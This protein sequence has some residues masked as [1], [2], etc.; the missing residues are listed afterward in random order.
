MTLRVKK[1]HPRRTGSDGGGSSLPATVTEST[2]PR[3]GGLDLHCVSENGIFIENE[4]DVCYDQVHR[5]MAKVTFGLSYTAY[6]LTREMSLLQLSP[7]IYRWL[8]L[9]DDVTMLLTEMQVPSRL[10]PY[11]ARFIDRLLMTVHERGVRHMNMHKDMLSVPREEEERLTSP[12]DEAN[13]MGRH[14][15]PPFCLD[16]SHSNSIYIAHFDDCAYRTKDV[17]LPERHMGWAEMAPRHIHSSL[18]EAWDHLMLLWSLNKDDEGLFV[19]Q[20]KRTIRCRFP[21]LDEQCLDRAYCRTQ[22]EHV[23]S[24]AVM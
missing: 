22:T 24:T 18:G 8:A 1:L 9:H 7:R 10:R 15:P 2:S 13:P 14:S 23:C 3:A 21:R 11:H 6:R 4:Q 20:W 19:E 16:A 12:R 5:T 17:Y